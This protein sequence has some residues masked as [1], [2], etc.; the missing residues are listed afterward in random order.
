[1]ISDGHGPEWEYSEKPAKEQLIKLG[2]EYKSNQQL[3]LERDAYNQGLLLQRLKKAIKKINPWID[4][5][6]VQNT[7][8]QLQK[9]ETA[10]AIDAN[11]MAYAR[12]VGLSRAY[13][14]PI[15]VSNLEEGNK[16]STVKLID[17]DDIDNNEFLVTRQFW[18]WGY[19]DHVFPD[20]VLFV[21]GIPVV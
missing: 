13:L 14:Q 19:K 7:L 2:Y 18:L 8:T 15:T 11:E 10:I 5:E 21:N 4:E 9:F 20:V 16:P 6:G 12:M 3:N 1:L 17:F